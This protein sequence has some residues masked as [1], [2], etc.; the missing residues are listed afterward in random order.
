MKIR[1]MVLVAGLMAFGGAIWSGCGSNPCQDLADAITA[2]S[3]KPHCSSLPKVTADTSNC[4]TD[5][6]T[7]KIINCETAAFKTITDCSKDL[8]KFDTA[9]AKCSTGG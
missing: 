2:A 1:N 9:L 3:G 8:T 7:V 4:P 5:D 6:A